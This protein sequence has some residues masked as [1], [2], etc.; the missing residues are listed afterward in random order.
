MPEFTQFDRTKSMMRNLPPTGGAGLQ[1]FSVSALRRSPRPPAMMTASVPPVRRL[2]YRPDDARA[3]CLGMVYRDD[4]S[5]CVSVLSTR[6]HYDQSM[7][8]R[9]D[10]R[11]QLEMD[12]RR[13]AE[14]RHH[15]PH[16]V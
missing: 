15:D 12:L 6:L 10:F 13:I 11:L 1:R 7:A 9:P 5:S 14:G 2:T 16:S 4:R 8:K 3:G